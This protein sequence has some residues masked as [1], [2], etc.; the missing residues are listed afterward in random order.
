MPRQP[1]VLVVLSLLAGPFARASD[2]LH[3]P[4]A[5]PTVQ[6][7]IDSAQAGDRIEVAP[8]T[9]PES[10]DFKGKDIQVVGTAGPGATVLDGTGLGTSV[11]ILRHGE[12]PTTLIEGFT[13]TGGIGFTHW[14]G[15][16]IEE[17]RGGGIYI[18]DDAT[19]VVRNCIIRE[20]RVDGE[21]ASG[22]GAWVEASAHGPVVFEDCQFLLNVAAG[23]GTAGG[24]IA[25]YPYNTPWTAD[26]LGCRVEGNS[27]DAYGGGVVNVRRIEDCVIENNTANKHGGL[28]LEAVSGKVVIRRTRILRNTGLEASGAG[29]ISGV[30]KPGILDGVEILGNWAGATTSQVANGGLSIIL[31]PNYENDVTL[32][33]LVVADNAT[34]YGKRGLSLDGVVFHLEHSTLVNTA[35]HSAPGLA[36]SNCVW[37]EIPEP[38]D[39]SIAVNWS[40][41]QGGFPGPGNMDA[42]PGFVDRSNWDFHVLEG[43]PCIDAG[44]PALVPGMG[45][46]DVDGDGRVLQGRTDVG[47]DEYGDC[48][49]DGELDHVELA[50]GT[51]TDC[52]QDGVPDECE[53]TDC[54]GNGLHDGCEIAAGSLEDCDLDGVPDE[55]QFAD[56]NGNGVHDG[57]DIA[58][59]ASG[60]CN[61]NGVPDECDIAS[62]HSLDVD[63][64]GVPD[65][66]HGIVHVPA[67]QPDLVA[68]LDAAQAGDTIILADGTW[69]GP[70]FT[71]GFLVKTK[72]VLLRSAGGVPEN[73]IL[74]GGATGGT[75]MWMAEGGPVPSGLVVRGMTFRGASA[76][77][78]SLAG[79]N[80]SFE[81]CVF[82]DNTAS[83]PVNVLQWSQ[84]SFLRCRFVGN[85]NIFTGAISVAEG[86]V[87]VERCTFVDNSGSTQ[88]G[89]IRAYAGAHVAISDSI[90]RGGSSGSGGGKELAVAGGATLS[91]RYSNVSGGPGKVKVV[92]GTLDWGPGNISGDPLFADTAAK[93][94]HLLPGSPCINA[95]DPAHPDA[96]GSP[97]EMGA[98]PWV[99]WTDLGG[100]VA[101]SAGPVLL[102]GAG[103]LLPDTLVRLVLEPLRPG[104]PVKVFVGFAPLGQAYKGGIFWP[105]ADAALDALPVGPQGRL[106]LE[107][108]WPTGLASAVPTWFQAWWV[109]PVSG[110]VAGSNG[111][112]AT[113]P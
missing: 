63:G 53:F 43:S 32:R 68:A 12:P 74:Q 100:G 67:D 79:A 70:G 60:D 29:S 106:E 13:I 69:S 80:L 27:A 95:G 41:V 44:D 56:C 47:A 86:D 54:N 99:A 5:F 101:G 73:C 112:L 55:C 62:G 25:C 87:S 9:Y 23:P 3:V 11:V 110:Q 26:L 49:H 85:T 6:A 17:R 4:G 22:G 8:G 92:N 71:S 37:R 75:A 1:L 97:P 107:G 108:R 88:A 35:I 16:Q 90:F 77:V 72:S 18:G 38:I 14:P 93:D 48:D 10:I 109:D 58:G 105:V 104:T 39:A 78:V 2:V 98:F 83:P 61:A 51:L 96:D 76:G 81:D 66:C 19:P 113:T 82:A 33:N 52:D 36:L 7:A 50:A 46:F 84:A 24:G 57:C 30:L 102:A 45:Y 42:E 64:N 89:S 15:S 94:F 20:N 111:L 21:D 40:N 28:H 31:N 91:V 103:S 59:G 65:E 34:P